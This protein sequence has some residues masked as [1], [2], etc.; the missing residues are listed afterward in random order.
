MTEEIELS[1][2]M[3]IRGP[4]AVTLL[5]AAEARNVKPIELLA[6]IIEAVLNDDLVAAVIDK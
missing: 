5:K 3:S 1:L 4:L 2:E 6:D